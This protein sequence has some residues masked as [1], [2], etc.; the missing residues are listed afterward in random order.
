ME[1]KNRISDMVLNHE[2]FVEF[3]WD[4]AEKQFNELNENENWANLTRTEQY[5]HYCQQYEHQ[6]NDN[7][8][9]EIIEPSNEKMKIDLGYAVLTAEKGIDEDYKEVFVGLEDKEGNWLQDLAIVGGKYHYEDN[10]VIQDE[11]LSVKVYSDVRNED[12]THEFSVDVY[13]EKN[14]EITNVEVQEKGDLEE[15]AVFVV[16]FEGV[17]LEGLYRICDP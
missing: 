4:E 16:E 8:W 2:E 11:G 6:I 14:Y 7:D 9:E 3:V 10:K 1:F 15:Y 13:K 17:P 12:F 5:H